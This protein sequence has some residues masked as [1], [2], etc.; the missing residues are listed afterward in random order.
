MRHAK[1][2]WSSHGLSDHDRPLNPRGHRASRLIGRHL[3]RFHPTIS[4]VLASTAVRVQ[5][6]L[7][8]MQE[9][10]NELAPEMIATEELYLASP[11]T[12]LGQIAQLDISVLTA[13]VIAHN[14][15]LEDLAKRLAG[16][17]V[18]FPTA[19]VAEFRSTAASWREAAELAPWELRTVIRP[20]ELE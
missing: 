7:Q 17:T 13:I 2:D 11:S 15:G 9:E 10:W 1:S 5:Q 16:Q 14:P 19:C 3:D 18:D 4:V 6:T 12:I 20:R 8:L